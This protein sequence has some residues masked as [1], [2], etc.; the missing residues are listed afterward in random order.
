MVRAAGRGERM[1]PLTDSIPKPLVPLAGRALI[2]HVLD[3]LDAAGITK[4]VVNVHYLPDKLEAHLKSRTHPNIVISDERDALLETGG[5]VVRALPLLGSDPFLIHNSD[6]VW[7]EGLGSNLARLIDSWDG[8][9]MDT[10]LLLAST[11]SSLGYEGRG[12]FSMDANGA[13]MRQSGARVAPFVFAGV[14]IAHPRLFSDAPKGRFSLNLLWDRAI[15]RGRAY[16]MRLDGL[17]MH[18]GTPEAVAEAD[19]AIA[20]AHITSIAKDSPA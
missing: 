13:L 4:A 6:T 14:S 9:R 20:G 17:W 10:L 8:E 2:D 19:A 15:A 5:G 18:V 12:D 7:I 16:G 1:R 11:A 3:R